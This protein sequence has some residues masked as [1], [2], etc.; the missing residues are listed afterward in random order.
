MDLHVSKCQEQADLLWC[1]DEI[2]AKLKNQVA[3]KSGPNLHQHRT[4]NE[5]VFSMKVRLYILQSND[6][7]RLYPQIM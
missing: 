5:D 4:D 3:E 6:E 1:S 2:I 7:S